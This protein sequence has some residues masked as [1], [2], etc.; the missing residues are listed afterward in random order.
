LSELDEVLEDFE[1]T[2]KEFSET[3]KHL[4]RDVIVV[5]ILMTAILIAE[6]ILLL[7]LLKG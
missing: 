6:G 7:T 5:L 2:V 3:T 1:K 4:K